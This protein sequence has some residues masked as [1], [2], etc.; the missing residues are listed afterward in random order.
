MDLSPKKRYRT[1]R[2]HH[3]QLETKEMKDHHHQPP[4][5]KKQKKS[6]PCSGVTKPD[7]PAKIALKELLSGKA[8][9]GGGGGLLSGGRS[10]VVC[11]RGTTADTLRALKRGDLH[12]LLALQS[13]PG[14]ET[15]FKKIERNTNKKPKKKNNDDG[16]K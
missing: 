13:K 1:V 16:S 5:E 6:K 14:I 4:V 7:V 10:S 8:F 3:H 9:G 2:N 12:S 15:L 11:R